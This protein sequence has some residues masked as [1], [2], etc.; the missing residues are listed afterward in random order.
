M[1]QDYIKSLIESDK[2]EQAL[3]AVDSSIA[4]NVAPAAT[5]HFLRGKILWR[6]GRRSEAR[7]EYATAVELDPTSPA[8]VALELAT[9]IEDFF[10]P[11]I[12]NP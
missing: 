9:E 7:R 8:R 11:D 4:D 2:L 6:L 10:N 12:Y 1:P 5:Y 3:S